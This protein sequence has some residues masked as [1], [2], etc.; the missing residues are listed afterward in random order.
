MKA[1]AFF[2]LV[3]FECRKAFLNPG[4]LIFFVALLLFNG[5]KINDSYSQKVERW[6][7]YQI[8]YEET[9]AQYVGTIT[10]EKIRALKTVYDPLK[11]KRDNRTINYEYDPNAYIYSEA[12]DEE[13]YRTLF[14]TELEYDYLYQNEAYRIRENA[15]ELA[16][17][18]DEL[19]N[20]FEAAKNRQIAADFTGRTIP[21][22]ADT[23]GYEVLL[24]YDYSGMLVLLLSIFALCGV[25]VTERETDMYMLLRTTKNGAGSTV[26]AKLM[27]SL[28]FV[29]IVCAAFFGQDFLSI[30]FVSP[31]NTA[32][33][34]P[35]YTLRAFESTH[36]TMSVGQYFLSAAVMKTLGIFACCTAIL[37][38]SSLFKQTLGAFFTGIA[39]LLG[40][41]ALQ[42]FSGGKLALRW[43]DPIELVMFRELVYRDTFVNVLGVPVRLHIFVTAGVVIV[44]AA[45]IGV[46][47]YLNRS[48][49]YRARRRGGDVPV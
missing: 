6:S 45:M 29:V 30:Y 7:D 48:Y 39:L 15:L 5:W 32:L 1:R 43:F 37:L 22:F 47:L 21:A 19:G 25:F 17:F 35:I 42:E 9:Y 24:S 14:Y 38:I 28:L 23:R 27:A 10:P 13:F 18:Y 4:M 36:M 40:F 26:V 41:T 16:E 2:R 44:T 33:Q 3:R 8:Q 46:I 11:V 20:T 12:M 31:R 49:H 34:S